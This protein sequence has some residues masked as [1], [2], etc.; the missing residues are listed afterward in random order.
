MLLGVILL[1]PTACSIT[2]LAFHLACVILKSL[3]E[4]AYLLGVHGS[5]YQ[6]YLS[7]TGRFLPRMT[8]QTGTI[9]GFLF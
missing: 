9:R 6:E 1:L 3:D 7:K 8:K 4:E 5:E 2:L